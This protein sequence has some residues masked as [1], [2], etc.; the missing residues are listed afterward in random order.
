MGRKKK[1]DKKLT[2]SFTLDTETAMNARLE[3]KK[4]GIFFSA[5]VNR[6]LKEWLEKEGGNGTGQATAALEI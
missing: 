6:L 5:L 1:T 3:S 2:I 4:K